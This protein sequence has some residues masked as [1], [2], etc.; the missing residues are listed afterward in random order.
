MR[1]AFCVPGVCVCDGLEEV[2]A[3]HRAPFATDEHAGLEGVLVMTYITW[4][5][6]ME[7]GENDV[8]KFWR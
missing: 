2:D 8:E 3:C 4:K 5:R 1:G 7:M 6:G